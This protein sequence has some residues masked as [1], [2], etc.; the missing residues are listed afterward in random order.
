MK[1]FLLI[2]MLATYIFAV[3]NTLVYNCNKIFQDRKNQLL[4]QLDQIDEQQQALS[5]LKIATSNLL[6]KKAALIKIEEKDINQKLKLI[7]TK[8]ASAK[9]MLDKNKKILAQMQA[10]TMSAM[11]KTYSKMKANAAASILSDMN[12]TIAV[13]ILRSLNPKVIGKIFTQMSPQKAS[14]LTIMLTHVK[15]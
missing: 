5:A 14:K 11:A 10:T 2:I 1:Y 8:E 12:A 9:K 3:D 15:K 7:I 4:L 13:S 6:K